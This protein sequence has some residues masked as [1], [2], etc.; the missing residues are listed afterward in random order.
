M[1]RRRIPLALAPLLLVSCQRPHVCDPGCEAG[2][3]AAT[4]TAA[5]SAPAE[6][7]PAASFAVPADELTADEA[8]AAFDEAWQTI[9]DTHFDPT[10][11][12]VDWA[13]LKTELR[14]RAER[15]RTHAELREVLDDMLG[16]LGQSHFAVIPSDA[17]PEEATGAHD[18]SG[19][20]GF[21]V[22]L[23]AGRLLVVALEPG[24]AAEAAG[25]KPGWSVR[26]IGAFDTGETLERMGAAAEELGERKLA[27]QLWA[28]ALAHVHG[29]VGGRAQV[30]F[31]DAEDRPVELELERR[32]RDVTV[33]EVGP[34]LPTFYLEFA[35]EVVEHGEKRIGTLRF[36][37]WFLP[38]V[39]P[40][41]EAIDRMRALDGIVIDLRGN[42][43][44][45]AAMTMGLSGHFFR[46]SQKLGVMM[47]RDSTVNILA[48]PRR[49]NPSGAL[50]EPFAGPLAIVIDETTGSAS[51]V[52][53]GGMQ[54]LGRA[55]VFGETSAG[56]VLPAMTTRL[57]NGD[58]MLHALGDFETSTGVRLE[59]QG[60]VPD[61]VVGRTRA[62]LLA[63]RDAPLAAALDW[64]AGA[65][66]APAR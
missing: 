9:H 29:P 51:E 26:R 10:F 59:G 16:R 28:A 3:V 30:S 8:L 2:I 58:T 6:S 43:G 46:E 22:R 31:L 12:G 41:D 57:P 21:D 56:A 47:T 35:S 48:F 25:V 50:V 23:R 7:E 33:H 17:L 20:L 13:A 18:Q 37:N 66:E 38:V 32:A 42:T 36:S 55:R 63:G 4:G 61:V 54:A 49:V 64:I 5:A 53:A 39:K 34:T 15:A 60:V 19:G 40:L 1:S 11:N 14:P 52:F 24:G 45:A 65:D 27:F 44:G 62:D